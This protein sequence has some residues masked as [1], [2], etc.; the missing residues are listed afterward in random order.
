MN[1]SQLINNA[2]VKNT[3]EFNWGSIS[4]LVN[5]EMIPNAE[6]TFGL[7]TI[8]PGKRNPLHLHPNCEEV[9]YLVSGECDHKLGDEIYRLKAG[10]AI[11]IPR[12]VKHWA[13]CTSS[14][15]LK[16]IISFSAPN[17]ET[18]FFEDLAEE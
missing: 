1:F 17:R 2:N 10:D 6:Q 16:A 18:D 9:L 12:D 4:W 11:C 15:P 8:L 14:E 13:F 7:V 3:I 5:G